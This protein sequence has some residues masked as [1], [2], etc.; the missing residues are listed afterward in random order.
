MDK[1]KKNL[2]ELLDMGYSP[3]EIANVLRVLDKEN[4]QICPCPSCESSDISVMERHEDFSDVQCNT[5]NKEWEELH[6]TFGRDI[7]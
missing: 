6:F 3:N 4:Y 7:P 2:K 1:I 5:C